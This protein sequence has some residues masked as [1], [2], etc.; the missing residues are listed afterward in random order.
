MPCFHPIK[1]YLATSTD[2]N[3]KLFFK[4]TSSNEEII[5][6]PCGQCCFC[7][8]HKAVEWSVRMYH[9]ARQ[10][11]D[12]CFLTMTY[13]P[14]HVPTLPD[15]RFTL[16]DY[17]DVQLFLK[18]LRK[19]LDVKFRY[20]VVG[21]Y[22]EKFSRPHY[23]M[24]LFGW[25]PFDMRV[26]H[27]HN[28]HPVYVSDYLAKVWRHGYIT[29]G[30]VNERSIGYVSKYCMKKRIG[31]LA[32][33]WYQGRRPEFARMS[34]KPGI[35]ESFCREYWSDF[36]KVDVATHHVLRD[37]VRLQNG[38]SCRPPKYYDKILEGLSPVVSSIIDDARQ[39]YVATLD[40]PDYDDLARQE[41]AWLYAAK[42]RYEALKGSNRILDSI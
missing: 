40:P 39:D 20:Y 28:G 32:D 29:V 6:V 2:G 1:G 31:K 23:H 17:R 10:H 26:H 34:L 30:D 8:I 41:E 42:R 16:S 22:G 3:R 36:Y 38:R 15:G 5:Y 37:C 13:D 11:A 35:G 12:S 18:R 27:W 21:E 24:I 14:G 4:P 19:S 7:R 9:E 33:S 25:K